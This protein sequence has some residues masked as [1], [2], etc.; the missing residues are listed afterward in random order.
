MRGN[1]SDA[2]RAK[3]VLIDQ[4]FIKRY[5]GYERDY[6]G[7]TEQIWTFEQMR[8]PRCIR[9]GSADT[10]DVQIGVV[11]RT[12]VIRCATKKAKFIPWG[13]RPGQFYCNPCHKFFTPA[14]WYGE[15]VENKNIGHTSNAT[16]QDHSI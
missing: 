10:A 12:L 13:P 6:P 15:I 16:N 4:K 2:K 7:I 11:G 5:E 1:M 3:K 8:L 9:C 14:L